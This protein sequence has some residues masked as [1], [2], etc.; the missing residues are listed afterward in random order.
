MNSFRFTNR[1]LNPRGF[2]T[3]A[4][5]RLQ[6]RRVRT[7]AAVRRPL[8]LVAVCAVIFAC[9]F[10]LGRGGGTAAPPREGAQW[11]VP[12]IAA[13]SAIPASLGSAPP[14]EVQAPPTRV[15]GT[16]AGAQAAAGTSAQTTLA[17]RLV[18]GA[19]TSPA[20]PAPPAPVS[21]PAPQVP[22]A[23]APAAPV[24]HTSPSVSAPAPK[25]G[26]SGG[27]PTHPGESFDTS[28]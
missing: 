11:T 6:P 19:P 13:G 18:T 22:S 8:A 21:T 4:E 5:R 1:R 10:A 14:I 17:Q 7:I 25:S 20:S 28:G 12:V 3:Q 23:P 2:Q 15:R 27:A 26:S 16:G 24:Q 9:A